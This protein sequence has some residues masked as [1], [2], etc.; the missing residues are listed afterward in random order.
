L[1]GTRLA[2]TS[3]DSALP[4]FAA[5]TPKGI[6][7]LI[8]N[9]SD[10]NAAFNLS[11]DLGRGVYTVE[12]GVFDS[13]SPATDLRVERLES[14]LNGSAKAAKKPGSLAPGAAAVYR[15]TNRSLDAQATFDEV[16]AAVRAMAGEQPGACRSIMIPLSEC[17]A[18]LGSLSKGIRPDKRY[19]SLRYIHRALMT[20]NH[21]Q[22]LAQNMAGQGR[23][24]S[25][26]AARL[27]GCIE[28]LKDALTDLSAGCLNLV[29]TITVK[30]AGEDQPDVREVTVQLANG[31]QQSVSLVRLGAEAPKG[32]AVS[33]SDRAMFDVLRPGETAR[34]TFTVRLPTESPQGELS[35]EFAWF[36]ARSP[37]HLR[38]KSAF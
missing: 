23:L 25:E 11:V 10:E 21:A 29:P 31:G 15:F 1:S 32:S 37:A 19:D 5:R 8:A 9:N 34:A 20:A 26:G 18:H 22:A 36:A 17:E 7:V 13:K 27:N 33:P 6:A 4:L 12:R 24:P 3:D 30:S 16:R 2:A 38:I 28:R 35:G 14:V